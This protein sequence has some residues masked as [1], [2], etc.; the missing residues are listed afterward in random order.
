MTQASAPL[1][2]GFATPVIDSQSSFRA[3][4][5]ALSFP[6]RVAEIPSPPEAPTDWPPGLAAA[7]L[8]LLDAEAPVWIDEAAR[9][10]GAEAFLRFHAGAPIVAEPEDARFAIVA[11]PQS[12]PFGALAI[13]TDQYPDRSATALIALPSLE[14]GQPMRL[15][16]PGI[17]TT[18]DVAPGG[19]LAPFW[20]AWTLNNG[21]YPLGFDVFM[22]AG[23]Q[24]LG[25]PRGVRAEAAAGE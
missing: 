25:L 4:M 23:A 19:A 22:F 17:Q 20:A 21:L 1:A 11:A 10:P 12:A 3:L 5:R 2:A 15:S 18:A 8:T 14:G 24:V 16:G 6:G 9:T 7:A 13:G